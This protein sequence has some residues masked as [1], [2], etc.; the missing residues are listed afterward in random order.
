M[1]ALFAFTGIARVPAI[2]VATGNNRLASVF[3][4]RAKLRTGSR[5]SRRIRRGDVA[6]WLKAAVC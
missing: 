6:E 3:E 2:P 4:K 1:R 5:K